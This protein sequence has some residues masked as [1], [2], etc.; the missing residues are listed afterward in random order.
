MYVSID[1]TQMR[2]LHKH[3]S[4]NVVLNLVYLECPKSKCH[5]S[6]IDMCLKDKTDLEVKMLYR[7]MVGGEKIPDDFRRIVLNHIFN[8]VPINDVIP[9]EVARLAATVGNSDRKV[10]KYV[11]GQFSSFVNPSIFQNIPEVAKVHAAP[12]PAYIP[13]KPNSI[14][15]INESDPL[16]TQEPILIPRT[17]RGQGA[18]SSDRPKAGSATGRVWDIADEK[19]ANIT[20]EKMLRKAVIEECVKQGINK[21]TSSVQFSKWRSTK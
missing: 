14:D 1:M 17:T 8:N 13:K 19:S 12:P 16:P 5:V 10:Y 4:S 11:K 21:S 18:S 3:P 7:N 2:V 15:L 6:Q 9:D 20:D